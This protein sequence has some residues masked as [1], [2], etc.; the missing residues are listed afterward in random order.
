RPADPVER[1]VSDL[2]LHE[3]DVELPGL[4]QRDV[5][6]AALGI[7]LLEREG[8]VGLV[9]RV[10]DRGTVDG[11][12]AAGCRSP[13]DH[14]GRARRPAAR[15]RRHG[16]YPIMSARYT[17]RSH[18]GPRLLRSAPRP[19]GAQPRD[20]LRRALPYRRPMKLFAAILI[21]LAAGPAL[22]Q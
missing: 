17:S 14:R 9:N 20:G 10:G 4:E 11:K 2:A 1:L 13:E 22:A 21:M 12:S 6:G 3:R 19:A 8:A 5:L 15:R 18:H 7:A 16:G